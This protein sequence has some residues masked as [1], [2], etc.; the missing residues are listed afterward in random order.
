MKRVW[1]YQVVLITQKQQCFPWDCPWDH[2]KSQS[3][4]RCCSFSVRFK[5]NYTHTDFYKHVD[6]VIARTSVW[7]QAFAPEW[8][9]GFTYD[10]PTH[11]WILG[12]ADEAAIAAAIRYTVL[13]QQGGIVKEQEKKKHRRFWTLGLFLICR[14]RS[15]ENTSTTGTKP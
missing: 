11:W 10:G 8:A 1:N 15:T 14:I 6:D 4:S 3:W 9:D 12:S 7:G 5:P 2:N 13:P